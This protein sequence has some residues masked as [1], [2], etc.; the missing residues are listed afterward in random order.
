L[1]A[2]AGAVVGAAAAAAVGLAAAAA[3][4]GAVG[5]AAGG[6]V[7]AAGATVGAGGAGGELHAASSPLAAL[8]ASNK[9]PSLRSRRRLTLAPAKDCCMVDRPH[10][11]FTSV[12][13]ARTEVCPIPAARVS[14]Q[15]PAAGDSGSALVDVAIVFDRV[16]RMVGAA[17]QRLDVICVA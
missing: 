9:P 3:V 8:L 12:G 10:F 17:K 7:G 14:G 13:L 15:P 4:G 6:V 1:A 5:A 11:R 2:T 16:H